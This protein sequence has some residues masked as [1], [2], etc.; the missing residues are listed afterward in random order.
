MKLKPS[1]YKALA[2]FAKNEPVALFDMAA[3]SQATRKRM[4]SDGLLEACGVEPGR[5]GFTKFRRTPLGVSL[6]PR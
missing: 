6:T 5:F 3:P 1:T 4:Q 2:W